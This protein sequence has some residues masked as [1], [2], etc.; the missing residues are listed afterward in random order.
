[1]LRLSENIGRIFEEIH[2]FLYYSI[3]M[4]IKFLAT[5]VTRLFGACIR[6]A[7]PNDM[8]VV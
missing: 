2:R 7:G 5:G 1:M 8:V 3:S 4:S 6:A